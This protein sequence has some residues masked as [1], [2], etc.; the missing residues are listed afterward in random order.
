MLSTEVK[1]SQSSVLF[2]GNPPRRAEE[3]GSDIAGSLEQ[4]HSALDS[5]SYSVVI[6]SSAFK[7]KEINDI[8]EKARKQNSNA[9]F[10]LSYSEQTKMDLRSFLTSYDFFKVIQEKDHENLQATIYGALENHNE[11][12]QQENLLKLFN[13][14]NNKLLE[15]KKDLEKRIKKREGNI[16]KAKQKLVLTNRRIQAMHEA[17]IAL[18]KAVS[19]TNMETLLNECLSEAFNL[20]WV[21]IV[22]AHQTELIAHIKSSKDKQNLL[23]VPL[24][25]NSDL[26][27]Y[28]F[29]ARSKEKK[30]TKDE[31]DFL[32]QIS[33]TIAI[34][35]D[36][37]SKKELSEKL[38]RQWEIT[39]N[40]ISDPICITDENYRIV[41]T[42]QAFTMRN[43]KGTKANTGLNA[44]KVFLGDSCDVEKIK[45]KIKSGSM[46][47]ERPRQ[48][49]VDYFQLSSHAIK[50]QDSFEKRNVL[51]FHDITKKKQLE[52]QIVES[53]K[54]AELGTIS[55]SIAHE[56]NNPLGGML[57]F[58]QLIKMDL[59]KESPHR[60][61]V[62]AMVS[63]G[64]KCKEIIEN[65]LGFSRKTYF[66]IS[67]ALDVNE[68]VDKTLKLSDLQTRY[69]NI[70]IDVN[71]S[72]TKLCVSGDEN[73]LIQALRNIL[74]NAV[75][76]VQQKL[77]ED[78]GYDGQIR[79]EIGENKQNVQITVSDNGPGIP[80]SQQSH[81]INPLFTTKDNNQHSGL[82]L[83]IAHQIITQHGGRLEIFSQP[84]AGT[85]V[86]LSLIQ[87][88]FKGQ[89]T[90]F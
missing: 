51:I 54:L 39:F 74:Q 23:S 88:R 75:E 15:L 79:I 45:E 56:L 26:I 65:L 25:M 80:K 38:K 85:S 6:I 32:T 43:S 33:E 68:L 52:R 81:L 13:D 64:L 84:M 9:Q 3:L 87:S 83:T 90:S 69:S 36:R 58:L 49:G 50:L 63:A 29:Y 14:Q 67:E 35:I 34:A 17:L 1:G 31:K 30:F 44:F 41:Q 73:Q 20:S 10:V 8:I 62:D 60:A 40:A 55:S 76:A 77:D 78:S 46:E 59:E 37:I 47:C 4:G 48:E 11:L 7:E 5:H 89:E 70:N 82:G 42:N 24:Y 16:N 57:S 2:I 72:K 19:L 28:C 66:E 18:N 61:D 53:S 86:K 22:F 27:G 21:R 71:P 12:E